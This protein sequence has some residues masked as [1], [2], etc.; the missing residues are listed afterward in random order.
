MAIS[1]AFI[2][3]WRVIGKPPPAAMARSSVIEP[4]LEGLS[5][6]APANAKI[7]LISSGII[8]TGYGIDGLRKKQNTPIKNRLLSKLALFE[9]I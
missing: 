3:A 6:R 9:K 4:E 2:T 7:A 1:R 5:P 8:L